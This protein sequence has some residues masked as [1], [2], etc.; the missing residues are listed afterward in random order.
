MAENEAA[1]Q[2][3][4]YNPMRNVEVSFG[5]LPVVDGLDQVEFVDLPHLKQNDGNEGQQGCH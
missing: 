3:I 4:P 1:E 2:Q 5:M